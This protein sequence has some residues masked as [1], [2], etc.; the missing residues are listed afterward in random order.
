MNKLLFK[1]LGLALLVASTVWMGCDP[2]PTPDCTNSAL[3]TASSSITFNPQNNY[4]AI[5]LGDPFTCADDVSYELACSY[6]NINMKFDFVDCD[7][8]VVGSTSKL[9]QYDNVAD[10]NSSLDWEANTTGAIIGGDGLPYFTLP[11]PSMSGDYKFLRLSYDVMISQ[12]VAC[13][14][15]Y[16]GDA[17]FFYSMDF[18][19]AYDEG[20][21]NSQEILNQ[22]SLYDGSNNYYDGGVT[23]YEL[24]SPPC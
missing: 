8:N 14:I 17:L 13:Q 15:P 7:G 10:V 3:F 20:T 16:I 9:I 21:P 18:T 1:F 5:K 12:D 6:A 11:G 19:S 24:Y 23:I 2:P 4:I 22:S